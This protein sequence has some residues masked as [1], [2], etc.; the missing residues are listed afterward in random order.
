VA[1]HGRGVETV[2]QE[3]RSAKFLNKLL[4]VGQFSITVTKYL[5]KII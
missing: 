4:S 2:K 5:G 1:E 3:R